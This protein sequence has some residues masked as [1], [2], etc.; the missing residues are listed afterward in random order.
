M[1]AILGTVHSRCFS[2]PDRSFFLPAPGHIPAFSSLH[3]PRDP[4]IHVALEDLSEPRLAGDEEAVP[5][6]DQEFLRFS[7]GPLALELDR[8]TPAPRT[9]FARKIIDSPLQDV[10]EG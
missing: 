1:P 2:I 9:S 3:E 5:E 10:G 6:L 7:P 8:T 4:P